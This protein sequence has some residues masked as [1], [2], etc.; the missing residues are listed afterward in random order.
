[1]KPFHLMK[2]N[3]L[4][5]LLGLILAVASCSF[6]TK[7]IDPGDNS[8]EEVLTELITFVL[9]NYHYAPKAIDDGFSK[10]VYEQY[11]KRLDP[12]KRFFLKS[13][14]KE[15]SKYKTAIDDQ[16]K[17]HQVDFFKLTYTRLQQR[18]DEM[19][20]VYQD[21]LEEG[22]D[23]S[24]PEKIHTEYEDLAYPT[25]EKE[26]RDRWRKQLKFSTL[27]SYYNLK[28][29]QKR[30]AEKAEKEG[31][32]DFEPK[33]DAELQKEAQKNTR[34]AL[35]QFFDINEDLDESD[36]FSFYL[37]TIA[38]EF[39]PH[40]GYF[41]PRDKEN[42][43]I[44][45]SGS[46]EGIGAQLQKDLDNI[47]VI[48]LISGG[49]AWR[50]GRLEVGDII[51]K[52][53]QEDEEKAVSIVG[54]PINDAVQLIRGPKGSQVILT[55]EKVDGSIT[56]IELTRD[57][58][59]L[60]A[61]YARSAITQKNGETYGLIKLPSFYFDMDDYEK[62]NAASDVRKQIEYLKEQHIDGLILDLRNNGGGSLSTAIDIAGFFIDKGPVV[63]VRSRDHDKKVLKDRNSSVKWNGSLVILVNELSASASEIL[64]AAMQDYGRAVILGSEQTYGKGT[65]QRFINLNRFMRSDELGNMGALKITTQKFYRI[66]GGAT[67]L[68]GVHSD[69]VVPDRYTFI[70]IGERDNEAPLPWDEITPADYERWNGYENLAKVIKESQHRVDTTQQFNYITQHAKWIA[71]HRDKNVFPLGYEAFKSMKEERQAMAKKFDS[72][73]EY[74]SN[75]TFSSLPYEIQ[76]FETDSTL[77][78]K[79]ERW[80]K[81]LGE[82]IYVEEAIHILSDLKL[83]QNQQRK[84]AKAK[85]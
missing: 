43:D 73:A 51:K 24:K 48:R 39:D 64:A 76:R 78:E 81:N 2:K 28:K 3:S 49:P 10:K 16:L 54:M 79:R 80:H 84:V 71:E 69:V 41:A 72:L 44:N 57:V 67:Q 50:D 8:K 1:M 32:T 63:Q 68:K 27:S 83:T 56:E 23:F 29:D 18:I 4:L 42:F 85:E 62:R 70:K 22:F 26:R 74:E 45:M 34:H 46:L 35:K 59:Q 58:V 66:N 40:T 25:T 38:H 20:K 15:F 17:N 9:E 7:K 14:I 60:E 37:N 6:T 55:V 19:N 21:I 31:D 75:L 82:D 13:D 11:L 52:V 5:F 65:V 53:R 36:W 33:T 77:Q 61:T 12:R 30:E 47:K